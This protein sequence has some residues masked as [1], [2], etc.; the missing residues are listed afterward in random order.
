[1]IVCGPLRQF[2][3]RC[4]QRAYPRATAEACIVRREGEK[5][6]VDTEH[7]AYPKAKGIIRPKPQPR[8][9]PGDV[10]AKLLGLVGIHPAPGCSC[11]GFRQ[12]MNG[13][14]W[15]G[16]LAHAEEIMRHLLT[17]ARGTW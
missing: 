8:Y 13:W 9:Q 17:Q 5:V 10:L 12:Q 4:D 1:V 15:L 6:C 11:S 2:H 14:G 7:A 16:C 3:Q